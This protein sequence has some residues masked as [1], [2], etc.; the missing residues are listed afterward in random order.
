MLDK[1][2]RDNVH[3][4]I[5]VPEWTYKP[6]W[7]RLFSG[8]WQQRVAESEFMPSNVLVANN[9]HCF[10]G[11]NFTTRLLLMRVVPVTAGSGSAFE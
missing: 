10:F 3:A 5:I 4:V 11:E 9:K 2:E 1:I 8:A 6:W 7:P